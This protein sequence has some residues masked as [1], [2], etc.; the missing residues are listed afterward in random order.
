VGIRD[1]PAWQRLLIVIGLGLAIVTL[2]TFVQL[3]IM[4]WV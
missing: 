2:T 1:R 3:L 4:G